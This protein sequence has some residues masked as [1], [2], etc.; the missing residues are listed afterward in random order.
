MTLPVFY[1]R[2]SGF[3][4]GRP[5]QTEILGETSV[6]SGERHPRRAEARGLRGKRNGGQQTRRKVAPR[7]SATERS[8]TRRA[9]VSAA[10]ILFARA[11]TFC[12]RERELRHA[13]RGTRLRVGSS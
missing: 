5:L 11:G 2:E 1:S 6:P 4:N 13:S 9:D 7:L 8:N 3:L 12:F 10:S